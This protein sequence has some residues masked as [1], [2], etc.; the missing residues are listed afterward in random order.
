LLNT[1]ACFDVIDFSGTKTARSTP[2]KHTPCKN[3]QRQAEKGIL[4]KSAQI[5]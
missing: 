3:K 4:K 1:N 2:M 5:R